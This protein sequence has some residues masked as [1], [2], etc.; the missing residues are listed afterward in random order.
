V[1]CHTGSRTTRPIVRP[2]GSESGLRE[3]FTKCSFDFDDFDDFDEFCADSLCF[4]SVFS[5]SSVF[6]FLSLSSRLCLSDDDDDDTKQGVAQN[7]VLAVATLAT[8]ATF[9]GKRLHKIRE[10]KNGVMRI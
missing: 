7:G 3:M 2:D 8:F 1:A 10:L 4:H 6:D 5:V 9:E